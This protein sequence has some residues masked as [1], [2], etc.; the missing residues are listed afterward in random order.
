MTT[1]HNLEKGGKWAFW[2]EFSFSPVVAALNLC[3]DPESRTGKKESA[4]ANLTF[5]S[6]YAFWQR[7]KSSAQSGLSESLHFPPAP[8]SPGGDRYESRR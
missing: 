4:S 3:Q 7:F 5:K 6:F 2:S 8:L 1:A